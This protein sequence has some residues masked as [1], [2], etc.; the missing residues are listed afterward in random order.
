MNL[1][2]RIS[3]LLLVVSQLYTIAWLISQP[4]QWWIVPSFI[5]SAG[6]LV[7]GVVGL[8]SLEGA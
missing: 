7:G 6:L 4:E 5:T 2:K 1:L 3:L 8:I